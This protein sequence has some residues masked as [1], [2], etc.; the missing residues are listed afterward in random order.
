MKIYLVI[1]V[2]M[3]Y[4]ILVNFDVVDGLI[5]GVI[6]KVK[7]IEYKIFMFRFVIIWVLFKDVKIGI[8]R[9]Y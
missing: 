6:C 4:D 5:N 8:L 3:I 1:V 2:D 9:R 7:Y